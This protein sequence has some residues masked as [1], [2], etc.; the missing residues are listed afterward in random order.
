MPRNGDRQHIKQAKSST[1]SENCATISRYLQSASSTLA[2]SG[3]TFRRCPAEVEAGLFLFVQITPDLGP[4]PKVPAGLLWV[5][6]KPEPKG[7]EA[8]SPRSLSLHSIPWRQGD[9]LSLGR[10]L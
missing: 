8:F 7:R 10:L 6:A 4:V 2:R 5:G 9:F 3:H 1:K